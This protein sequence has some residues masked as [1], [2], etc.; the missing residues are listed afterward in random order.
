MADQGGLFYGLHMVEV[1]SRNNIYTGEVFAGDAFSASCRP[2][3]PAASCSNSSPRCPE[4][5]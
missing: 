3:A 1:D 2:T 5:T 4:S